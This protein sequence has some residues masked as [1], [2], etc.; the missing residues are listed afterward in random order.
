MA[1]GYGLGRAVHAAHRRGWMNDETLL[2]F[3]VAFGFFVLSFVEVMG[4]NGILAVFAGGF[5]VLHSVSQ[6][7]ELDESRVQAM[8][9]R[10]FTIPI[11]FLFG[12]F[13]PI[14]D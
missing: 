2:S 13:L 12:L 8:M 10:L 11:F 4:A 1:V 7:E 14:D 9:E 5:M 6:R 3:T